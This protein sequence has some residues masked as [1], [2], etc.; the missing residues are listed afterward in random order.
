MT[1]ENA[2]DLVGFITYVWGLYF[3]I[4]KNNELLGIGYLLLAE[5]VTLGT[6]ILTNSKLVFVN[7][8]F[9]VYFLYQL[10]FLTTK[11]E[12]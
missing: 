11:E 6:C 4:F 12:K 1:T 3:F 5:G 2:A 10:I 8:I 9:T 7:L